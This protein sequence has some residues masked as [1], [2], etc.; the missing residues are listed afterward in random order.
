MTYTGTLITDICDR[1]EAIQANQPDPLLFLAR[2]KTHLADK[3]MESGDVEAWW[4]ADE[5]MEACA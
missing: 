4:I 1:V 3:V 5:A 2:V